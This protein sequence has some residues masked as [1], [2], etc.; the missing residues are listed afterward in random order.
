MASSELG[1]NELTQ[2]RQVC[3][4]IIIH[5]ADPFM[6]GLVVLRDRVVCLCQDQVPLLKVLVG[7]VIHGHTL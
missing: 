3:D 5:D 4:A 7:L 6:L 1:V 2:V